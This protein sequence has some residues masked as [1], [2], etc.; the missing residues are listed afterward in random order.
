V[1]AARDPGERGGE[2]EEGNRPKE[3]QI[4]KVRWKL[5]GR[6]YWGLMPAMKVVFQK[7]GTL[8]VSE[9]VIES[10]R[11]EEAKRSVQ[12]MRQGIRER[13]G[14]R[15]EGNRP[16]EKQRVKVCWKLEGRIYWGLMPAMKVFSKFTAPLV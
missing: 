4:V 8:S 2:R 10:R 6:I 1:N 13:E 9:S 15:E 11:R 14:E 7:H 5:E 3:K 16:K 12:R